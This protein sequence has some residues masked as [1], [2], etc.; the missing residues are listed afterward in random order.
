ME[1][2]KAVYLHMICIKVMEIRQSLITDA[3]ELSYVALKPRN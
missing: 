3:F 2:S 1:L